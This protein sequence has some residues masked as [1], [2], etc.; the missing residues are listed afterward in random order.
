MKN[1]CLLF[2]TLV[3]IS[4]LNAQTDSLE[5]NVEKYWNEILHKKEHSLNTE[6]KNIIYIA[7][8]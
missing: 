6:K 2:C 8:K 5:S 3:L 1:I 7:M 4:T